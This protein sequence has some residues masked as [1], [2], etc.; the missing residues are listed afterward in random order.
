MS[1]DSNVD[2]IVVLLS[3]GTVE[4]LLTGDAEIPSEEVMLDTGVLVDI[5]ILKVGHHGSRTSTSD[6]FL[7]VVAPEI[8][9]ISAGL[10]SQYGHPHQEVV[11][12]LN[13]AGVELWHTDI[14]DQDD[15]IKLVSNC[16]SAVLTQPSVSTADLTP[17]PTPATQPTTSATPTPTL[18]A[19]PTPSDAVS[20][21]YDPQG[22]DRD[23]KDFA[24]WED[25]QAFYLPSG[26][27]SVDPHRL[28]GDNDGIACEALA[29][30]P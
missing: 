30:A 1:G 14:S 20:L 29:G 2:S 21:P 3:C 17:T 15:T 28:D 12:S 6:A 4:I 18:A 10:D 27:P 24:R 7:T 5:D 13:M 25:A 8:G 9:I 11:D 22:P 16:Q 19:T 23:C 26:G